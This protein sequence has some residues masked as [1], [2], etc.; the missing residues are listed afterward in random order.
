MANAIAQIVQKT[1]R[2]LAQLASGWKLL[3]ADVTVEAV[4]EAEV[5]E[6]V[7]VVAV[8][9]V[10]TTNPSDSEVLDIGLA[11]VLDVLLGMLERDLDVDGVK[12]ITAKVGSRTFSTSSVKLPEPNAISTLD[13]I[14]TEISPS[15]PARKALLTSCPVTATEAGASPGT[16]MAYVIKILPLPSN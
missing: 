3:P 7:W 2:S 1:C 13:E 10:V 4:K 9:W 15:A 6:R 11:V 12:L 8:V 16:A 5:L 14:A